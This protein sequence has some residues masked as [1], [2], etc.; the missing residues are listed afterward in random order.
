MK[1]SQNI[2]YLSLVIGAIAVIYSLAVNEESQLVGFV[3]VVC[4]MFGIFKLIKRNDIIE[5]EQQEIENKK[6]LDS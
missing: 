1:T 5:E 2:G 6:D 4:V 3:G